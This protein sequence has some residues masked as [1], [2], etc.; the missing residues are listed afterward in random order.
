MRAEGVL[1]KESGTQTIF[2]LCRSDRGSTEWLS[3][4]NFRGTPGQSLGPLV[5]SLFI[6]D[7]ASYLK[8]NCMLMMY[9]FIT[10]YTQQD[11]EQLQKI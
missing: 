2:E 1:K 10:P 11:C 7:L 8:L 4:S 3:Y 9:Y 6:N 5:I